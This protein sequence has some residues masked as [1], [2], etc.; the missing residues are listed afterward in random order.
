MFYITIWIAEDYRVRRSCIEDCLR[1]G[2]RDVL[3][4]IIHGSAFQSVWLHQPGFQLALELTLPKDDDPSGRRRCVACDWMRFSFLFPF[5]SLW[6]PQRVFQSHLQHK[7]LCGTCACIVFSARAIMQNLVCSFKIMVCLFAVFASPRSHFSVHRSLSM[8]VDDKPN[9]G[10][11]GE[12]P[13]YFT[14]QLQT[15]FKK[16]IMSNKLIL[17]FLT[18]VLEKKWLFFFNGKLVWLWI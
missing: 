6:E 7:H 11:E 3:R 4:V 14:R 13:I 2:R 10:S 8:L 18:Y 17:K 9:G 1:G 15:F 16:K 12:G 5:F